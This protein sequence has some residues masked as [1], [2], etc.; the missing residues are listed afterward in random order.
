MALSFDDSPTLCPGVFQH[1]GCRSSEDGVPGRQLTR[2]MQRVK[3]TAPVAQTIEYFSLIVA[4]CV[5]SDQLT[6]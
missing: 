5:S 2:R 3:Q 6:F 4:I 1:N